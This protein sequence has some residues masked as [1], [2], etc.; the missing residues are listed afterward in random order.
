MERKRN[1]GGGPSEGRWWGRAARVDLGL[2]PDATAAA[3][4]N[5]EGALRNR[6][7]VVEAP[8]PPERM[9]QVGEMDPDAEGVLHRVEG[10]GRGFHHGDALRKLAR[11][12]MS[13]F[14]VASP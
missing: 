10:L 8:Q 6:L 5:V 3:L 1:G 4:H 9:G 2:R 11:L 14:A 12:R 13:A 7:G